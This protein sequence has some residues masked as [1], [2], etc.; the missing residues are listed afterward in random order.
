MEVADLYGALICIV[1]SVPACFFAMMFVRFN[2]IGSMKGYT[3]I[4][5]MEKTHPKYQWE[6]DDSPSAAWK[7]LSPYDTGLLG[8]L[9]S[10]FGPIPLFWPLPVNLP[11][12]REFYY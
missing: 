10:V 3:L 5:Y 7:A 6:G 4:E 8:N 12:V 9:Q 1:C 2:L 11:P